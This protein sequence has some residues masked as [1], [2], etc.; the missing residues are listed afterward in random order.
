MSNYVLIR[1]IRFVSRFTFYFYN[2]IYFLTTFSILCK[3]F[4]KIL[5][6]AFTGFKHG[7]KKFKMNLASGFADAIGA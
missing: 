1:L 7:L 4:I 5:R 6:F 2:A 3:R